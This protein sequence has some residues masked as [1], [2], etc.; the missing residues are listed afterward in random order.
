[1]IHSRHTQPSR[2]A[3]RVTSGCQGR[4]A[5]GSGILGRRL[6]VIEGSTVRQV[7]GKRPARVTAAALVL[8]TVAGCDGPANNRAS[9]QETPG[10]A[11]A[12]ASASAGEPA[13]LGSEIAERIQSFVD[14]STNAQ[15]RPL[16]AVI[17][18]VAGHTV[19]ERYYRGSSSDTSNVFSVTGSVVGTLIGIGL[20]DGSLRSIDQTLGELLPAYAA[21]MEA[22]EAAITLRELLTMT[23]GLQAGHAGR[24][25][26]PGGGDLL[27]A[28]DTPPWLLSDDWVR[29]I[30]AD[31]LEQLP[32]QGF[33]YSHASSHLLSAI[34]TEAVGTSV[35]DYARA[36]LFDPLGITSRPA[37]D[38]LAIEG[39]KTAYERADFA[40][41]HDPQGV[42]TGFSW[43]KL[44]AR[45]M[46]ALG[47]LYLDGGRW[48]GKQVVP[49]AWVDAATTEQVRANSITESFGYQWWV[50]TAGGHMA[51]AAIGF[52]GQLIEVVPDLRLVAVFTADITE[53]D[54]PVDPYSYVSLLSLIV[55]QVENE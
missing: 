40:W 34:L 5:L 33:A 31:R 3:P 39:N 50:T 8:A 1:V 29:G 10:T 48:H 18:E 22:E 52:G 45:D 51:Y 20:S 28:T 12:A 49:T 38:L 14:P 21:D 6:R 32:G 2:K 25:H 46:A 43:L 53:P 9:S 23:A 41:P 37:A 13:R 4:T 36:N 7:I 47:R 24:L 16:R 42:Q 27:L 15:M 30:L 55:H 35:L 54:A 11:T 26:D 44:T 19:L 17:I